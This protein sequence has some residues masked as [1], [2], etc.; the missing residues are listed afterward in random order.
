[1]S[2][3][4]VPGLAKWTTFAGGNREYRTLDGNRYQID[5]SGEGRYRT[6]YLRFVHEQAHT[7]A[8]REYAR[9]APLHSW[10]GQNG[11]AIGHPRQFFHSPQAAVA[12]ANKHC[13]GRKQEP[14][15][16]RSNRK[17]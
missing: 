7:P 5:A 2:R 17:R 4:C 6:Y 15:D 9:R 16:P 11:Q 3:R 14:H 12:A 10:I 13:V 1:M 8:S